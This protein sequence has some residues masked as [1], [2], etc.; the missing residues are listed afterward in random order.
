MSSV[1]PQREFIN[2]QETPAE[3]TFTE[4]KEINVKIE[5]EMEDQ[6]RLL[7]FTRIPKII[8]HRI[9]LPQCCVC[10]EEEVLKET[11]PQRNQLIS[12]GESKGQNQDQE[13]REKERDQKEE[14]HRAKQQKRTT[15]SSKRKQHKKAHPLQKLYSCK[16][17]NKTFTQSCMT[18][19]L[20][21]KGQLQVS[22]T[23]RTGERPFSCV[24][25]GKCFS[26]KDNLNIHMKLH[27]GE[28]PFSCGTCEKSFRLK[29]QL[30]DHM[31]IHTGKKPFLCG[32]CGKSYRRKSSLTHHMGTH[33]DEK[34]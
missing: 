26:R 7:D 33:L 4:L 15:N 24:T 34:P 12:H 21:Q 10:K 11:E 22:M 19:G 5:E 2:E 16:I 6:R 17:C 30:H 31:L 3:E 14:R 28:K 8:L 20:A 25:C 13:G 27:T 9:D 32:T 18:C 23:T 29:S 1:Q